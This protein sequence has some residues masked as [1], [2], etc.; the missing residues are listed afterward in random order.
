LEDLKELATSH[1]LPKSGNVET[2]RARMIAAMHLSDFDLSSEGL[3]EIQNSQLGEILQTFGIKKS[4]SMKQ[5]RQRIWLHLNHDPK[6]LSA[7]S[8]DDMTRDDLHELCS[9]LKLKKSGS[10]SALLARVAGVLASQEGAWGKVKKS[11]RRP[12]DQIE[13]PVEQKQEKE[14]LPWRWSDKVAAEILDEHGLGDLEELIR[15][16]KSHDESTEVWPQGNRYLKREEL[17]AAAKSRVAN[18][19]AKEKESAIIAE[20]VDKLR[21][22]LQSTQD[23]LDEVGD[24]TPTVEQIQEKVIRKEGAE[25]LPWRWSDNIAAEIMEEHGLEDLAELIR[26]AKSH[27]ESTEVWPEGNRYLKR[28]ELQAAAEILASRDDVDEQSKAL[29]EFEARR[30]EFEAAVR[31]FLIIG[32][33]NDPED[34]N[35]FIDSLANVGLNANFTQ[36]RAAIIDMISELSARSELERQAVDMRPDSWRTREEI[37]KFENMRERLRKALNETISKAEGDMVAARMAFEEVAR[38]SGLDLRIPAVSGRV[39]ALFDLQISL[40]EAEALQ[41]PGIARRERV[42]AIM[43]QGAVHLS[44]ESRKTVDRLERSIKGFE[45][46]VDAILERS[47]GTFGPAEQALLIRFLE[48]RGHH[49]NTAELRA[50]ILACAG[51]MGVELGHL[52]HSDVPKLPEG[53]QYTQTEVD[54]VVA[55]LRRIVHQFKDKSEVEVNDEELQLGEAVADASDRVIRVRKELDNVD[56]LLNRLYQS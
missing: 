13:K 19:E 45:Q 26:E 17:Q 43:Q 23:K 48:S 2:L 16:A 8:L 10:K 9:K 56:S 3:Q 22:E 32:N 35:A 15:E 14:E 30:P 39:H 25:E 12:R 53:M 21:E 6:K 55:D 47:E 24:I 5:R 46:L 4:G 50:R 29:L 52:Q 27:D 18:L 41:D 38:S 28:E 33:P 31:D 37:R 40:M 54:A 34:V 44:N 51:I 36:V 11:L 7:E 42:I 1:D 20:E 49:V